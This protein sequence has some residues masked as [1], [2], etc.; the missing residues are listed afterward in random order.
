[1]NEKTFRVALA[2]DDANDRR[3]VKQMLEKLGHEVVAEASD[4]KEL[5]EQVGRKEPDLV[6]SDLD[7]PGVD[8]LQAADAISEA[9]STPVVIMTST[10]TPATTQRVLAHHSVWGYLVKPFAAG[11][12]D[13][14]LRFSMGLLGRFSALQERL[15]NLQKTFEERKLV[16]RAKG[17]LMQSLN[18]AEPE[19]HRTLQ[20]MASSRNLKLAELAQSILNHEFPLRK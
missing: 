5:I 7:M 11:M 17:V 20:K 1:M 9:S 15:N 4:G 14:I 13:G 2:D 18:L 16:E 3:E 6:I 19:A 8:G 12:L 10:P